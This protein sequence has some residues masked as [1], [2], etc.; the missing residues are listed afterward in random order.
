M[1]VAITEMIAAALHFGAKGQSPAA[2]GSL[3]TTIGAISADPR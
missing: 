1:A 2:K 3:E